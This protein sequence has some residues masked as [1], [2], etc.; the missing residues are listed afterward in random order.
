L[1]AGTAADGGPPEF[2]GAPRRVILA[3]HVM[4]CRPSGRRKWLMHGNGIVQEGESLASKETLGLTSTSESCDF[5][6]QS[7]W[8]RKC[9]PCL[10]PAAFC[11]ASPKDIA[12]GNERHQGIPQGT[13]QAV[14]VSF[15]AKD[16]NNSPARPAIPLLSLFCSVKIE[17]PHKL[18]GMT[19]P[20]AFLYSQ[21]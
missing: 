10:A 18:I 14:T 5:R 4:R 17:A 21:R 6:D 12:Q 8:P 2:R 19:A 13:E 7:T 9:L 3:G 11:R 15:D 1:P 16:S 20:E